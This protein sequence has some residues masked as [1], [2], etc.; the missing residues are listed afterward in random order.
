MSSL[1]KIV[2]ACSELE[3]PVLSVY[4][5][6]T[7]NWKRPA[8]EVA[9]L[10]DLFIEFLNKELDELHQNNVRLLWSGN[11]EQVPAKCMT[12][13]ELAIRKTEAN[14]GLIFNLAFNY[15]A[16]D[17]LNQAIKRIVRDVENGE[18]T[19]EGIDETAVRE[20]LY[21]RDLPDPDLLIRTAG[22]MRLSNFML[23]QLAYTE[24]VVLDTLWP[25]FSETALLSA[26]N[27]YTQRNR[28]YGGLV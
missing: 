4:A 28:K 22:E 27:I 17:E 1:K 18:L 20:R 10:M 5:F 26:L 7:E 15:G 24:I 3:I 16:R 19:V 23:W 12:L 8:E 11:H 2:R 9:Y 25:D 6:S 14:T 13:I 21:T